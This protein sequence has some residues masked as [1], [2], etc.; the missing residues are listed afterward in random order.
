MDTVYFY[1][2]PDQIPQKSREDDRG[3][4]HFPFQLV[5]AGWHEWQKTGR[6]PHPKELEARMNVHWVADL[7]YFGELIER[8]KPKEKSAAMDGERAHNG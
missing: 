1:W 5:M 8:G 7:Q 2:N 6:I 4:F 3:G